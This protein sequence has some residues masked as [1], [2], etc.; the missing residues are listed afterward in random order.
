MVHVLLHRQTFLESFERIHQCI[1]RQS[2]ISE[3]RAERE[4]SG[5]RD[6]ETRPED[7]I[8]F[9]GSR[10]RGGIVMSG[11]KHEGRFRIEEYPR[12]S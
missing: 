2:G 4:A 7:N 12:P 10:A 3:L 9:E 8:G 5:Q 6:D 11:E 1:C